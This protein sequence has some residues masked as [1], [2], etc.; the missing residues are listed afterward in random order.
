[1]ANHSLFSASASARWL[2]CPGSLALSA[3]TERSASVHAAEGTVAHMLFERCVAGG[4]VP[5]ESWIGE[6]H[7][8]DGHEIVVDADMLAALN[9]ALKHLWEIVGGCDIVLSERRVNYASWLQ[10]P[11]DDAFGTADVIAV[12]TAAKELIV[13]DYKH[14]RGVEVDAHDNP[15]L[16]LYAGG[17]LLELE[18]LGCEVETVRMVILQ[19]R[20]RSA[21][22]EWAVDVAVLEGWLTGRAR[23]GAA[24]VL[25]AINFDGGPPEEFQGVFLA[26]GDHCQFCPASATCPALRDYVALAVFD[27]PVPSPEGFELAEPVEPAEVPDNL[28]VSACLKKVDAIES[29]CKAIR[30]EAERR[31]L[32]GEAVPGFKIVAG[33]RSARQWDDAAV[34]EEFLRK[35][36]RLPIE[37]AYD[38]RVIS[39]TT[40]EKL[41]KAG[42]IGSRLWPKL[43]EHIVQV[44][45]KPHV[46]P[47]EDP[48]PALDVSPPLAGFENTSDINDLV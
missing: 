5:R 34:A 47:T 31:L 40:A 45:G 7:V 23:S 35:K 17:A 11:T 22:S 15:Q 20:V 28:W 30:A 6:R 41:A 4:L 1:M 44:P 3:D 10:V 39:P 12:N 32:A 33:K 48:R 46:A 19:P 9:A 36:C 25:N 16:M 13:V 27:G 42:D 2:A 43:Q 14:G 18:D 29:W 26:A 24:S 21:P 8:V 37:K 38:M